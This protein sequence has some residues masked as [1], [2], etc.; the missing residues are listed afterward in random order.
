MRF[1]IVRLLQTKKADAAE[2]LKVFGRVGLL[3]NEP[4]SIAGLPFI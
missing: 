4:P 2:H 3:V 1:A